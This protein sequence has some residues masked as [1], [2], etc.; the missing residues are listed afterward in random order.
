VILQLTM[1]MM[2][3]MALTRELERGTMENLLAMPASPVEIMLGK[4]LPYLIVSAVQVVVV[5]IAA[6]VL[7]A[8]PFVGS[9]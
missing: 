6:K 3:S 4:V 8:V 9:L 2:T 5:L 7:F 1:V